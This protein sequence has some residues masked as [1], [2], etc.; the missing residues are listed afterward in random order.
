MREAIGG[1]GAGCRRPGT[2]LR[3][4]HAPRLAS[5]CMADNCEQTLTEF[6][7]T[8]VLVSE[9]LHTHAYQIDTICHGGMCP[10]RCMVLLQAARG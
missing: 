10:T 5:S 1:W 3:W 6:S 2:C 9:C 7:S 8:V 4:G